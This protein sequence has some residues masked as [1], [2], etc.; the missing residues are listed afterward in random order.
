MNY[1]TLNPEENQNSQQEQNS[2]ASFKS[3]LTK[4]DAIQQGMSANQI[5]DIVSDHI[6]D[7]VKRQ[8]ETAKK[9]YQAK[10]K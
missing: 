4:E 9:E 5:A 7:N 2:S 10:A 6:I 3:P 1:I 8:F